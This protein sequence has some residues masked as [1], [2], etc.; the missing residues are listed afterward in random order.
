MTATLTPP[1]HRFV[2]ELLH[3][4]R[5]VH[6][7]PLESADFARAVEATFFEALRRGAFNNYDLPLERAVFE[8]V[9]EDG[10]SLAEAF[11]V[12]LPLPAGGEHRHCFTGGYFKA[13][14]RQAGVQLALAG[15]VPGDAVLEYC[16]AAYADEQEQRKKG[17]LVI[18]LEPE[19]PVI[20]IRAASRRRHGP[21]EAWDN[22]GPDD[23]PVLFPRHVLEESV[24]MAHQAP[25]REIGGVLLGHLCRDEEDGELFLEVSCLV[26]AE[27]TEATAL[28]V[29]FTHQTWARVR[30]VMQVRGEAELVVGWMHSHPFRLCEECPVPVPP[31]CQ[32]K[33]LFYSTDDEFLMELSF[34]RP[35]MVGLLAAVEPK[36]ER[37]LGHLP[38]KLF[39]W[40]GGHIGPRGFEVIDG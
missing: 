33:V 38:V 39:G 40:D 29:T 8:P 5:P 20:P 37:T 24:E 36:L 9:L 21:G 25:D 10:S 19:Q 18:D 3:D 4:G 7:V 34:P 26:P 1:R 30:E 35:F 17:G 11:E 6:S 28:S 23:F 15:K 27:E 32:A 12:V 16:L 13:L 2:L 14:A 22:P 31:E